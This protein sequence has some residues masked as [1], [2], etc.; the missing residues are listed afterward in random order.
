MLHRKSSSP[1]F[2]QIMLCLIGEAFGDHVGHM[3]NG[4]VVSVRQKGDKIGVWMTSCDDETAVMEVGRI[5]K[6]RL[7]IENGRSD[8]VKLAF[9]AHQDTKRKAG[10]MAKNKYLL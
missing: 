10:S 8:K 9:E 6:E 1:T 7:G 4:A 3:V 2:V 5:V